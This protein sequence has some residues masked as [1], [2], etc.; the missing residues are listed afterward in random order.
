MT[1]LLFTIALLT[2]ACGDRGVGGG[3]GG[4]D[5]IDTGVLPTWRLKD[6]QPLSART[7]ETYGLDAFTDHIVVVTLVAGF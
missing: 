3:G 4:V 6:I 1:R 2:A 5:A 7:G